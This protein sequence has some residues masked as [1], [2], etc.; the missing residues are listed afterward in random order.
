MRKSI[1]LK[2]FLMHLIIVLI[3]SGLIVFTS[4]I[5]IK[6]HYQTTLANRLEHISTVL[7]D[8]APSYIREN[9]T[10]ALNDYIN[11]IGADIKTRITVI[12]PQGIVLA[13]SEEDPL[14]MDNHKGRPEIYQALMGN[15]GVS[16][17]F[18]NTLQEYMLYVAV[19]VVSNDDVIGV[20]RS[21][22]FLDQIKTLLTS[23]RKKV[24][25]S[26]MVLIIL[27]LFAAGWY[28]RQFTQPIRELTE[29]SRKVAA[30]DFSAKLYFQN[31]DEFRILAD[32]FNHMTER[33]RMLFEESSLQKE[34]INSIV[35]SIHEALMVIDAKDRVRLCNQSFLKL[36]G[37]NQY[38]PDD[39]RYWE[40]IREISF[41]DLVKKVRSTQS[42]AYQEIVL[43]NKVYFCSAS[44]TMPRNEV[45]AIF[46]DITDMKNLERIKK[47]F[48]VNVSHELRTPLTAIKGFIETIEE[49][50]SKKNNRYI[51]IIKR[52]TE[53]MIHIIK[54]LMTLSEL[55]D[56]GYR[57]ERESVDLTKLVKNIM[58]MFSQKAEEK[59]V[60]ITLKS[61]S[62]LPVLNLDPFRIEQLFINLIDNAIKFTPDAGSISIT[63]SHADSFV[64]ISVQ[65][66]GPGIPAEHTQRIFERFYSVDKSHSRKLGGTGLGLSIVKHIVLLHNGNISVKSDPGAGTTFEIILP[67][68]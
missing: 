41:N 63:L 48:V 25:I 66:S 56:A 45:V 51:D 15:V 62:K 64:L 38:T 40:V 58:A 1:L 42:N 39:K 44:L 36:L 52:H 59:N 46:L 17:R 33:L 4:F 7:A 67:I 32:N 6:N 30:G 19:P 37:D 24:I 28:A 53:R 9:N 43:N 21:S 35:Y 49:S 27:A 34:E 3:L 54:D 60:S 22:F 5:T 55:E 47:D 2:L 18:S 10:S 8:H 65:D 11:R 16:K 29:A 61:D 68:A 26:S 20:V 23:L 12:D 31:S 14:V 13:D 57:L 50:Q